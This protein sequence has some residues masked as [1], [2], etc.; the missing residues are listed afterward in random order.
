MR[1]HVFNGSSESRCWPTQLLCLE[2]DELFA[3]QRSAQRRSGAMHGVFIW[4]N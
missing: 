3:N 2:A 1:H 4:H